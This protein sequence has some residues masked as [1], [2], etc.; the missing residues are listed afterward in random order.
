MDRPPRKPDAALAADLSYVGG[1]YNR[2]ITYADRLPASNP[3]AQALLYPAGYGRRS[4]DCRCNVGVDPYGCTR[5][6]GRR[7][8]TIPPRIPS[9]S[10]RGLMQFI[11]DTAEAIAGAAGI[12]E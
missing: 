2:A 4:A 9:A 1:R 3:S 12:S 10:A 8:N 6:S 11:P 5:S 7:A